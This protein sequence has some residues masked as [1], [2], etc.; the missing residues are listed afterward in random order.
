MKTFKIPFNR[1]S[2][3]GNEIGYIRDAIGRGQISADGY[4][5]QRC[6][7]WL[8]KYLGAKRALLTS[9]CTHALEMAFLLLKVRPGDEVIAPSFTFPST[10][11]AFVLWGARPR[12]I[13]IRPDTLNLDERLLDGLVSRRTR[14]VVPVHYAGVPC[15]MDEIGAVARRRRIPIVEDAAQALGATYRGRAAGTLGALSAF[16]FHETKNSTCGEGGALVIMDERYIRRAEIL[17]Q[18]GTNRE[19]FFRG[20]I[21]KYSWVDVGSSYAPS[22]LQTAFLY[23]QFL[24]QQNILRRR[25]RLFERYQAAL[26]PWEQRGR[27]RL[28]VLPADRVSSYHQFHILFDGLQDRDRVLAGLQKKGIRAVFHYF[29]LHRSRMG[30]RFGYR[31]GAC[32]VSETVSDS[33][34]RLPFFNSMTRIEQDQVLDALQKLL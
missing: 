11:N 4:Y 34:L 33:L 32:P 27:L 9:S 19:A 13:D 22:E 10:A 16:S 18:K 25:R 28:P 7:R 23:G 5:T 20:E 14:A 24:H 29:P 1:P 3:T 12:F 8:E 31:K 26:A 30:E 2:I 21:D 6:S 17:R 15:S